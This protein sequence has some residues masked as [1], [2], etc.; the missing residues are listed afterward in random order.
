MRAEAAPAPQPTPARPS[1]P[2]LRVPELR[3]PELRRPEPL[4]RDDPSPEPPVFVFEPQLEDDPP[5]ADPPAVI[6][7][8]PLE[9]LPERVGPNLRT[10]SQIPSFAPRLRRESRPGA[11]A[12]PLAEE[13][14][15]PSAAPDP[16]ASLEE[17]MASL[18]G[19]NSGQSKS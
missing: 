18:L 6:T 11:A 1:S 9:S 12:R 13:P 10:L 5:H 2:D 19:R 14:P 16:F 15:S 7:L 17:E 3:L 4:R 8:P